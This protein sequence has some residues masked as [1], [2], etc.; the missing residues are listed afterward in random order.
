MLSDRSMSDWR[1]SHEEGTVEEDEVEARVEEYTL[2]GGQESYHR[3]ISII[4]VA[5]RRGSLCRY[6]SSSSWVACFKTGWVG[7][8]TADGER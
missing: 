5:Q 4:A 8:Q 2:R 1:L 3:R 7:C 6:N